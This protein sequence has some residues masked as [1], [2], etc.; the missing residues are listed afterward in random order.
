MQNAPSTQL[1]DKVHVVDS[2]KARLTTATCRYFSLPF[3]CV[4]T[5]VTLNFLE[6]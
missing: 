3:Q 2:E 5:I 1:D 4:C 6:N